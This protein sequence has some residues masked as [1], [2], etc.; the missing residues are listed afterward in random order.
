M[1]STTVMASTPPTHLPN[2]S[3]DQ[4]AADHDPAN[5]TEINNTLDPNATATR[6]TLELEFISLLSNPYYVFYLASTPASSIPP[7]SLALSGAFGASAEST[8][9]NG[10]AAADGTAGANAHAGANGTADSSGPSLSSFTTTISQHATG[11]PQGP[12]LLQPPFVA[13]LQYLDYFT[14][15]PYINHL[16]HPEASLSMLKLLQEER[17]RVD[18]CGKGGWGVLVGVVP[19]LG[20][21]GVGG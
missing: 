2:T 6:F 19:E 11:S 12:L 10:H 16:R 20:G 8:V 4:M 3:A 1:D 17:F 7:T 15:P 13:Y 9:T 5:H 14:H 18:L 21:G